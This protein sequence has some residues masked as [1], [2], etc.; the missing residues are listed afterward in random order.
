MSR[1]TQIQVVPRDA[2]RRPTRGEHEKKRKLADDQADALEQSRGSEVKLGHDT[3]TVDDLRAHLLDA[4]YDASVNVDHLT[5]KQ[6]LDVHLV[7]LHGHP[8][9]IRS[10]TWRRNQSSTATIGVAS[11]SRS[12]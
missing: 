8:P 7:D 2:P 12:I 4:A 3:L 6:L 1:I 9:G 11:E 5:S 10:T